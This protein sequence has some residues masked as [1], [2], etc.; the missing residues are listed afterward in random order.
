MEIRETERKFGVRKPKS[1][2]RESENEPLTVKS[3]T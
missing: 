3:P 1:R 2:K